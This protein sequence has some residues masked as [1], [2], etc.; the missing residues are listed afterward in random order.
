MNPKKFQEINKFLGVSEFMKTAV[1]FDNTGILTDIYDG[2]I[3]KKFKDE[4]FAEDSELFFSKD[5]ADS[6]LGLIVNLDWFQPFDGVS[7]SIGVL[8]VSIVD[9]L[10][11]I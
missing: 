8:Y 9:L 1:S 6:H 3:W 7:H 11:G 5:N 2:D 4:P 10:C